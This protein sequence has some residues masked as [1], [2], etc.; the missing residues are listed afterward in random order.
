M[1]NEMNVKLLARL[2]ERAAVHIEEQT[3]R[4]YD[5][6][7]IRLSE[8]LRDRLAEH[9]IAEAGVIVP[10]AL[11]DDDAVRLG[12]DAVGNVPTEPAEIALCVREGLE[13]I[14]KGEGRGAVT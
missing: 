1:V 9:M 3:K 5:L 14:A 11:T 8:E 4:Q 6:T 7:P 13:R 10:R 2:L 12:A